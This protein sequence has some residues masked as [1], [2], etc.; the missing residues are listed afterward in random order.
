MPSI[1]PA[2]DPALVL[3]V[4]GGLPDPETPILLG[5]GHGMPWQLTPD[6]GAYK[7]GTVDN[8]GTEVVLTVTQISGHPDPNDFL[9]K[10]D[11][12]TDN[13]RWIVE[14]L[15]GPTLI[16][17][18]SEP[19]LALTVRGEFVALRTVDEAAAQYWIID[20]AAGPSRLTVYPDDELTRTPRLRR[21]VDA[22]ADVAR[23]LGT[24]YIGVEHLMLAILRDK[25]AVPT[26]LLAR[27]TDPA[28]LA[29]AIEEFIRSS[30]AG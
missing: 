30:N 5:H 13:Q 21:I 19:E 10:P 12:G 7:I 11:A 23:E 3:G 14:H 20:H 24:S 4:L 6:N 22:S 15:D 8:L 28:E 27:T 9:V 18:K 26:Q 25:D 2:A 1:Y 29:E 17:S 16:R